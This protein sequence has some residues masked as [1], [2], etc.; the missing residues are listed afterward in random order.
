MIL[1]NELNFIFKDLYEGN[2]KITEM[3]RQLSIL[4]ELVNKIVVSAEDA[5]AAFKTMSQA[6]NN[7]VTIAADTTDSNWPLEIFNANIEEDFGYIDGY[8]GEYD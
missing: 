3:E 5:G 2:A 1:Q 4:S 7:T 6:M 8:T